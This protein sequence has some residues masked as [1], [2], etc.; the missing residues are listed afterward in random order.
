[1]ISLD[2]YFGG[3]GLSCGHMRI[4]GISVWDGNK[5]WGAHTFDSLHI[6]QY[7]VCV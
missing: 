6:E 4:S 1:M 2:L 7:L 3:I 5:F